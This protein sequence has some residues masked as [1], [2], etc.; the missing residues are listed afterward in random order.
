MSWFRSVR[1]STLRST[2]GRLFAAQTRLLYKNANVAIGVTVV[3]ATVL[4]YLEWQVVSRR[5]IAAWWL[6]MIA[7]SAARWIAARS[8]WGASHNT[9][10]PEREVWWAR[11]FIILAGLAGAGWGAAGM[12]LYPGAHITNQ[13]FLVFVLG[14]MM[15]GG[16]SIL[17]PRPEAFLAF[18]LPAGLVPAARLLYAGDETHV[19]MG[20]LLPFLQ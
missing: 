17:A 10:A 5:A 7:V 20:C 11:V 2:S 19:A 13:V 9:A 4:A 6:Y 3:V 1:T 15:L 8:Y 14:G 16:V 12:A 18:L